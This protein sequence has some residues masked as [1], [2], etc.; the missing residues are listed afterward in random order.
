[1]VGSGGAEVTETPEM[2]IRGLCGLS[3]LPLQ[4]GPSRVAFSSGIGSG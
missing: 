3:P 1:M 4:L 2:F